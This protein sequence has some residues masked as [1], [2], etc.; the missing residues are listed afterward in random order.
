[1]SSD[2]TPGIN[3]VLDRQIKIVLQ[4]LKSDG[5]RTHHHVLGNARREIMRLN[6]EIDGLRS[7]LGKDKPTN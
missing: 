5:S 6:R 2:K 7:S 1:M 4:E 3:E